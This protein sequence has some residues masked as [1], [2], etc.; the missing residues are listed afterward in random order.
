MQF[1]CYGEWFGYLP[2]LWDCFVGRLIGMVIV[3]II[4]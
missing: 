4:G 1:S 3:Q 2:L